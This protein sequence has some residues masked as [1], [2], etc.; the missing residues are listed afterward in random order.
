MF[1]EF[2][3]IAL[4]A[5]AFVLAFVELSKFWIKNDKIYPALSVVFGLVFGV[6]FIIATRMPATYGEWIFTV[7]ASLAIGLASTGLYKVG[8]SI[9]GK[10]E[11]PEG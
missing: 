10:R 2:L 5:Q 6:G 7:F 3:A 4:P 1:E 11:Q 8:K 9:T